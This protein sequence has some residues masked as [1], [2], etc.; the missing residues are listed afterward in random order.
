MRNEHAKNQFFKSKIKQKRV[1]LATEILIIL[2]KQS[3]NYNYG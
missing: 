1:N 3:I 2:L